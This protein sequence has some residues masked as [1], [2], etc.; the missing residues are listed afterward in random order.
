MSMVH[1]LWIEFREFL[2]LNI[3]PGFSIPLSANTVLSF[4]ESGSLVNPGPIG[5]PICVGRPCGDNISLV[6][7]DP[8]GFELVYVLQRAPGQVPGTVPSFLLGIYKE[9]F[10]DPN[11]GSYSRNLL[12]DFLTIPGYTSSGATI[13]F[14]LFGINEHGTATIDR[15]RIDTVTPPAEPDL[16]VTN[17]TVSNSNLCVV[18]KILPISI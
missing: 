16:V 1:N 17:I 10:L 6:L 3:N 15:L 2:P 18:A 11:A 13:G 9:I 4:E 12:Q 8:R 5:P 14:I 7:S